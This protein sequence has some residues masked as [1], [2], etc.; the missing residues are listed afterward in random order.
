[1]FGDLDVA[2]CPECNPQSAHGASVL[3]SASCRNTPCV[4]LIIASCVRTWNCAG[5]GTV[6]ELVPEAPE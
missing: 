2:R 4:K 6:S 1:M 5:P 3:K